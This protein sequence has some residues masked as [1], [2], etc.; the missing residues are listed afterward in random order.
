M[1]RFSRKDILDALFDDYFMRHEGFIIVRLVRPFGHKVSTRFFP[2]LEILGKERY[3]P[4]D[5]VFFGVCPREKMKPGIES[6]RYVTA[7]WAGLD[8]GPDGYSGR[9]R[10]F[11]HPSHAA[12]A[13]RSFP[14]APSIIV[15]SGRGLHLYWLLTA[16][17]QISDLERIQGLLKNLNAYFQCTKEVGIDAMLR[18]PGTTNAKIPGEALDCH[19]KYLNAEFRY[20]LQQFEELNLT[21]GRPHFPTPVEEPPPEERASAGVDAGAAASTREGYPDEPTIDSAE[22]DEYLAQDRAREEYSGKMPAATVQPTAPS[23]TDRA[24]Q[25]A[26]PVATQEQPTRPPAEPTPEVDPEPPPAAPA[27]KTIQLAVTT[28]ELS[29]SDVEILTEESPHEFADRIA[30]R[31]VERLKAEL[32]DDLIEKLIQRLTPGKMT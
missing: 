6:I 14:L 31:I 12:K 15:E 8:M 17:T 3:G 21:A 25:P 27:T 20:D 9:Q 26:R 2:N 30:D 22:V 32:I 11:S 10:N 24:A 28:Q 7:L 4:E 19:V 1:T 16:V 18:L 13:I 29:D 23:E 5:N